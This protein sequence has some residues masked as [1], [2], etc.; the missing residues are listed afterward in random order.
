[1]TVS[2]T[3]SDKFPKTKEMYRIKFFLIFTFFIQISIPTLSAQTSKSDSLV[4]H[5]IHFLEQ[6]A[7]NHLRALY[8]QIFFHYA[9]EDENIDLE[10]ALRRKDTFLMQSYLDSMMIDEEVF[11]YTVLTDKKYQDFCAQLPH[12]ETYRKWLDSV[13]NTPYAALRNELWNMQFRDQG[14]RALYLLMPQETSD[15]I[16]RKVREEMFWVDKQNTERALSILDSIGRWPGHTLIGQSA[17]K[18]LWLCIQHADQS[19]E[20]ASR[21]LS[22]LHEAVIA[23]RSD[24]MFYAYLVDRVRMH[25]GKEQVYGT[26]T[27]KAKTD[28][29][30]QFFFVIPIEDVEHVDERR[31]TMGMESMSEYLKG[32]GKEWNIEQYRKELPV[33]RR[34]YKERIQTKNRPK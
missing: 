31:K 3:P 29:G 13:K 10:D 32:M 4:R 7:Q 21:Y 24:P 28:D 1:M 26:Q 17:D 23:K 2:Q 18:T 30:K 25:D 6:N 11:F 19:P 33:I 27:Y 9:L 8:P 20:V 22:M 5:C 34:Y 12:A 14:I 16:K 15:I